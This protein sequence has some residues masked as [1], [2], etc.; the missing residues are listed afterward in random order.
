ML[1]EMSL[2]LCLQLRVV[3]SD[4]ND[5]APVCVVQPDIQLDRSVSVGEL[6]GSVRVSCVK[7][8]LSAEPLWGKIEV[9]T[10]VMVNVCVLQLTDSDEGENAE[11]EFVRIEEE[12]QNEDLLFS[13]GPDGNITTSR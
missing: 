3:V 4:V 10:C 9:Y 5:N 13:I 12:L 7:S 1:L 8:F 6:V 2:I 11:F